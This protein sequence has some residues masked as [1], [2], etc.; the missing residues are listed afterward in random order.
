VVSSGQMALDNLM[1]YPNPFRDE[2]F[3]VF[4]HNQAGRNLDVEIHIYNMSG[5]LVKTIREEIMSDGYRSKPMRWNGTTEG[6]YPIS[7]GLYV[8]RLM[9]TNELGEKSELR[10]KLIF[11]R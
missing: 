3:F 7:K 1:N 9:V 10:S 8:Y 6:G 5:L 4:D 2:T 11:H